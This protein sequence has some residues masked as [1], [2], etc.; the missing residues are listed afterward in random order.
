MCH[1]SM[2]VKVSTE[3][4]LRLRLEVCIRGRNHEL[5][6]KVDRFSCFGRLCHWPTETSLQ[7]RE[8]FGLRAG[9]RPQ[10]RALPL[11]FARHLNSPASPAPS[12]RTA[13]FFLVKKQ[14]AAPPHSATGEPGG[15]RPASEGHP[16]RRRR[17]LRRRYLPTSAFPLLP[18]SLL[19]H[20]VPKL[21]FVSQINFSRAGADPWRLPSL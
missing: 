2:T 5:E 13:S 10:F 11:R 8:V 16:H 14:N 12:P 19:D 6:L 7:Y 3:S 21:P 4:P 9:A 20:L 18:F 15:R 1:S 17:P